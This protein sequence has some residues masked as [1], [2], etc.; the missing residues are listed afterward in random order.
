MVGI[1]GM[2]QQLIM[3]CPAHIMVQGVPF[4]IIVT[5]MPHISFIIS[6]VAPSPGIIMHFMPLS[7]MEQVMRQFIGIIIAMGI[8]IGIPIEFMV[9]IAALFMSYSQQVIT[10]DTKLMSF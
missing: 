7:V 8:D 5:S 2:P 10:S 6:I 3:G 9:F 1:I 4:F